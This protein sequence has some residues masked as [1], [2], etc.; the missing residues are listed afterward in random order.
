MYFQKSGPGGMKFDL[1]LKLLW[2][3]CYVIFIQIAKK[4]MS[5]Q[6]LVMCNT[7][8]IMV[9]H[10]F[11]L[12]NRG[13]RTT[14][15]WLSKQC[16]IRTSTVRS[17]CST[18]KLQRVFCLQWRSAHVILDADTRANSVELLM[19]LNL[20]PLHLEVKVN[21]C[22]QVH[23]RISGHSQATWMIFGY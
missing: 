16:C 12:W 20:L 14:T 13:K 17:A 7:C 4:I 10:Q 3:H 5:Q 1:R 23:K 22:I 19:K 15:S 21:I 2:R 9:L 8:V 6:S 18:E 11:L